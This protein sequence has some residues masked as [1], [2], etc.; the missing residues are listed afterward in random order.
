M[1][2]EENQGQPDNPYGQY[3]EPP[4]WAQQV[5]PPG[6]YGYPPHM[7]N[8]YYHGHPGM[9]HP[10]A[11]PHGNVHP[12][13]MHPGQMH[14]GMVPPP[15]AGHM[16][17]GYMNPGQMHPGQMHP[18][19]APPPHAGYMHPGMTPPQAEQAAE[20]SDPMF[21]QAQAML[22]GAL[23]EE[24]GMFKQ[25]LGTMGMNDK[26]FWKGAMVGAAAALILSNENV[27]KGLMG[28]V[29]NAGDM[30]KSG[31]ASVKDTATQTASSVK[32]NVSTGGEIFRDTYEAGKEGFRESVERHSHE[33]AS[34]QE[35]EYD[36]EFPAHD[37]FEK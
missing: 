2:N 7:M 17:P 18:G 19:M 29:S 1:S 6:Y 28:M 25:I 21:E 24:A 23:G 4:E 20:E 9:M 11:Y 30:L 5:P 35:T 31:G 34:A 22:E 8:P 26:E 27:R 16:H 12:G 37:D 13:H 3:G 15:Q 36:D 14:P 32:E 10:H 33:K